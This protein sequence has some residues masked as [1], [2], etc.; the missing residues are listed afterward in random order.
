MPTNFNP[1]LYYYSGCVLTMLSGPCA[2]CSARIVVS[3]GP[4]IPKSGDPAGFTVMRFK[5]DA[6]IDATSNKLID[7]NPATNSFAGDAFLVNGPAYAGMGRGFDPNYVAGQMPP[8]SQAPCG[9]TDPNG[10]E[11]ALLPNPA[12]FQTRAAKG[13]YPDYNDPA[14]WS[15]ANVDYTAYDHNNIYLGLLTNDLSGKLPR[16]LPSFHRSD[17][18][19]FWAD[20]IK[21]SGGAIDPLMVARKILF[22]PNPTDHPIFCQMTN[23]AFNQTPYPGVNTTDTTRPPLPPLDVDNVGLGTPDSI[24]I[25]PGLPVMTAKDG[26]TYKILVAPL[27]L[28][29]DGRVNLNAHGSVA[30]TQTGSRTVA[31]IAQLK[32]A[33]MGP[34]AG[35]TKAGVNLPAGMG[36]GPADIDLTQVM[37]TKDVNNLFGVGNKNPPGTYNPS[38]IGSFQG[39]HGWGMSPVSDRALTMLKFFEYPLDDY[40]Y[41]DNT[42]NLL[43]SFGTP[44][45]LKGQRTCGVDYRGQPLWMTPGSSPTNATNW[46]GEVFDVTNLS[47]PKIAWD[48]PYGI[49]L[50]APRPGRQVPQGLDNPFTVAELEP[51]LRP[52]DIDTRSLPNRLYGASA[53]LLQDTLRNLF[54]RGRRAP[55]HYG[56]LGRPRAERRPAQRELS[57]ADEQ[58]LDGDGHRLKAIPGLR[59]A[60]I[61]SGRSIEGAALFQLLETEPGSF[62]QLN[63]SG[64]GPSDPRPA[65]YDFA[66]GGNA[67]RLEDGHQ[68]PVRQRSGRR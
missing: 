7:P 41:P 53:S 33:S 17:L 29:L 38:A 15:G 61:P 10:L 25:D 59:R 49:D 46:A 5:T 11:Y 12:F 60:R 4:D 40:R 26:R 57:N 14:G 52:F 43:S 9:F 67:R 21:N 3:N 39:R 34:L 32:Q 30:Q 63:S 66:P 50:H 16:I 36:F 1:G 6:G 37:S 56:E 58:I 45:D 35:S 42:F 54:R 20:R 18:W 55:I 68:S 22:R 65:D 13:S 23:P 8:A 48:T 27:I 51:V 62:H 31:P 19:T 2:G 28:D 24:W 44:G 64:E 47:N